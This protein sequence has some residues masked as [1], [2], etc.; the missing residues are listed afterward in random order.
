MAT[1][2]QAQHLWLLQ[3]RSFCIE[4]FNLQRLENSAVLR[5]TSKPYLHVIPMYAAANRSCAPLHKMI[6]IGLAVKFL[7][8]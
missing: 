5:S 3:F 7:A 6:Q 1:L 4:L 8:S 2:L